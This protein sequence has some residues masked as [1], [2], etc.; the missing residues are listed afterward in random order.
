MTPTRPSATIE[1][2]AWLEN[3]N[4]HD[5]STAGV[6]IDSLRIPS[7]GEIR[8]GLLAKLEELVSYLPTPTVILPIRDL[9]DFRSR[10]E[11][12]DQIVAYK[13]FSPSEA[14]S[15]T[16][17]SEVIAAN[18][19]RDI[20]GIRAKRPGVLTPS[21]PI[22]DLRNRRCR[23]LI[24]V[25][26]Y[27][28]SGSKPVGY[29]RSVLRNSTLRSWRSFGWLRVHLLFFA[30]SR[31]AVNH[32]WEKGLVD[33]I[34]LVEHAADFFNADWDEQ[35]KSAVIDVCLRYVQPR[36]A[37]RSEALGYKG[38]AGLFVMPHT[39]PN[40]LPAV[41]LQRQGVGGAWAALFPD[42]LFPP[43]LQEQV[44]GYRP[45]NEFELNL[46][47]LADRRLAGAFGER[48]KGPERRYL[49][50]LAAIAGHSSDYESVASVLSTTTIAVRKASVTLR[51]W[52]LLDDHLHLT[53]E[54]W[55]ALRR[56]RMSPR[57]VSFRLNESE[58][59]YY[60]SQLRGADGV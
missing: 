14:Y 6:L 7:E 31:L 29:V 58:E 22:E 21:V 49:M 42:R 44:A 48:I 54:G 16:P 41:L 8:T 52:G 40:N 55:L 60:P 37:E 3:F 24:L 15:A 23:T 43:G 13:D 20:V 36:R 35:L 25:D 45:G 50:L 19:I 17:G 5:R 26:D 47:R 9:A 34:H 10:R 1:G 27:T 59:P 51:G 18:I 4:L 2:M 38:S 33:E 30:A 32:I 39:V 53:E 46:E 57:Q 11:G 28:G 12:R 56:A